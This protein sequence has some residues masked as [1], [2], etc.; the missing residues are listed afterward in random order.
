[1]RNDYTNNIEACPIGKVQKIIRG[2]WTM[3]IIYHLSESR[4]LRFSELRRRMPQVTEANLT[5]EL[6]ALEAYGIIHRE[7]YREVPPRVEYSLT[8][9]GTKFVPVL[10][11]LEAWALEY[12][13]ANSEVQ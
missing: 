1:M 6:R 3:V 5:K 12:E 2:K 7:I 13:V 4:V 10:E 11:A 9:L 8:A